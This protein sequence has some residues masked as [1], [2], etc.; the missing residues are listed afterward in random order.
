[1]AGMGNNITTQYVVYFLKIATSSL[2]G[3]TLKRG[4]F[5]PLFYF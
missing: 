3:A 1:M 4:Q 2:R 5:R